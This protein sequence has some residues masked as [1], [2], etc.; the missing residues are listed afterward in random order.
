MA[1]INKLS[2]AQTIKSY[3]KIDEEKSMLGLIKT[4]YY[5]PTRSKINAFTL[6]FSPSMGEKVDMVLKSPNECI[7]RAL[8]KCG[9]IMNTTI[10]HWHLEACMSQDKSFAALQLFKYENF[11][12]YPVSDVK[13]YEGDTA[14]KVVSAI[15]R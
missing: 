12:F 7:D 10:G 13:I 15:I 1:T 2:M 4:Y 14:R 8:T 5:S 3:P 11:E 9:Y 6:D